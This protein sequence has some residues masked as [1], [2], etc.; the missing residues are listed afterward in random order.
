MNSCLHLHSF[1]SPVIP[2]KDIIDWTVL[3]RPPQWL[4]S[5]YPYFRNAFA[6]WFL[7]AWLVNTFLVGVSSVKP[8]RTFPPERGIT[9]FQ[10]L[11]YFCIS[12]WTYYNLCTTFSPIRQGTLKNLIFVFSA[13]PWA[14]V[15]TQP[16]EG[17]ESLWR[18]NTTSLQ[19]FL[20][21]DPFLTIFT[22]IFLYSPGEHWAKG[23]MLPFCPLPWEV[24]I[25]F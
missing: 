9:F 23:H 12:M 17:R 24:Y 25:Q 11:W 10:H 5:F 14:W 22:F 15:K 19:I 20:Q 8:A 6:L 2:P 4:F 3:V 18:G 21:S 1:F 7:S 13:G 16:E